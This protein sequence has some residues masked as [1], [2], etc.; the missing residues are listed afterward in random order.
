MYKYVGLIAIGLIISS[1]HAAC[2]GGT[3]VTSHKA[4]DSGCS[5]STCNEK[6]FCW[7]NKVIYNWWSAMTWCKANGMQLASSS[8]LC[9]N[10]AVGSACTNMKGRISGDAWTSTPEN[11]STPRT[12]ENGN[13]TARF[14]YSN[15][16]Y[17]HAICEEIPTTNNP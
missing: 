11:A 2:D 7:S 8:S 13:L 16:S 17:T 14:G 15:A 9:P 1:A 3:W 6:T 12:Y 4:T 10:T 5:A